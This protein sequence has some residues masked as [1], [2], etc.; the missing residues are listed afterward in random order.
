VVWIGE[1][2]YWPLIH[3]IRYYTPFGTTSNYSAIANLYKSQITTEPAKPF[4]ARCV[5]ISR[6]LA[7]ASN[8]GDSSATRAQL[9][10]VTA[11]HAEFLPTLNRQLITNNFQA[12]GHFTPTS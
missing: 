4:P 3:T 9:L 6:S 5:F 10:F 8:N 12:G 7:T 11:A 2:I 1:W